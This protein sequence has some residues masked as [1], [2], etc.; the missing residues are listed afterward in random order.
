MA[1]PTFNQFRKKALRKYGVK[2]EYDAL[3]PVCE[4]KRQMIKLRQA[5]GLTQEQIAQETHATPE[6]HAHEVQTLELLMASTTRAASNPSLDPSIA[7]NDKSLAE[8]RT[9]LHRSTV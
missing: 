1:K 2:A 7:I 3:A 5:A 8:V 9:R 6:G 4:M